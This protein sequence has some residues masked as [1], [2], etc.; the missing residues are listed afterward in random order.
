M[1]FQ[2]GIHRITLQ[3]LKCHH[4]IN[5]SKSHQRNVQFLSRPKG[6]NTMNPLPLFGNILYNLTCNDT[7]ALFL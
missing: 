2:R 7:M 3:H 1:E 4:N 6:S 5:I